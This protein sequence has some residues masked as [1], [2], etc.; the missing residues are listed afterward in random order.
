M[1]LY[2]K[3]DTW[4]YLNGLDHKVVLGMNRHVHVLLTEDTL[5]CLSGLYPKVVL[6]MKGRVKWVRSQGSYTCASVA[7]GGHLEVLHHKDVLG[8]KTHAIMLTAFCI[9]CLPRRLHT[10]V[11]AKICAERKFTRKIIYASY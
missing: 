1:H 3:K 7:K 11:T 4:S 9:R 2:L 5:S 10:D 8:M 6:G